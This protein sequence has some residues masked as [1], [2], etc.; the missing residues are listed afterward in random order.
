MIH[1]SSHFHRL[2]GW[3]SLARGFANALDRL[4]TVIAHSWDAPSTWDGSVSVDEIGIGLGPWQNIPYTVGHR[5]IAAVCGETSLVPEEL[6]ANLT[7]MEQIWVP[8]AWGRQ[9][10]EQ[11]GV[12]AGKLRV[13]PYG[14]DGQVF[15]PAR[16]RTHTDRS[17]RPFRFL[18]VGKWERRKGTEGLVRAF[19]RAFKSTA[20]VELY[21][22]C[23]NPYRPD[24]D[25][26]TEVSRIL[27]EQ[28]GGPKVLVGL[29]LSEPEMVA[30]YQSADAFVLPSRGE[31]WGLPIL[32]A[33]ACG[34]PV[35]VTEQGAH[36][37]FV[38]P[39][40]GY[41]IR[42]REVRPVDDPVFFDP[43]LR[44]GDW[45]EPDW[46]HLVE[47]LRRVAAGPAEAWRRGA[48]AR[49][50][51][52]AWTWSHAADIAMGH[53]QA[54]RRQEIRVTREIRPRPMPSVFDHREQ[55]S[56]KPC[57]D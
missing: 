4:E 48:E 37:E 9:V 6:L 44:W 8:T 55:P 39:E 22:H 10:L 47:Q 36:R 35:L 51:S 1:L 3:G 20:P 15:R 41:L 31:G 50:A 25:V 43:R 26:A 42:A 49:L 14:V 11:S 17:S 23:D 46:D 5:R 18:C 54:L 45:V 32:E 27:A 24:L 29:P 57:H 38:R 30:L 7:T 21:L 40:H 28:G 56:G 2:G 13:V 12:P 16:A 34:L 53:I 33:M 19:C 52:L